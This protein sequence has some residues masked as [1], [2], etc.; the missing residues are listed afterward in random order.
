MTLKPFPIRL[1]KVSFT[2][3]LVVLILLLVGCQAPAPYPA[4]PTPNSPTVT[5]QALNTGGPAISPLLVG[6]NVWM[7]PDMRVWNIAGQAGL[8]I[9]R[10]G[11]IAYDQNMPPNTM[12]TEWVNNIKAMGAEPMIQVSRFNGPE[13]AAGV[14]KYFNLET[15]NRVKFWNIGNEPYCNKATS[16]TA[17]EVA[18]YIKPIASAMK[19]ADPTIQIFAPDEC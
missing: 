16:T 3:Y 7:Y 13:V 11:G 15:K 6:N 8:K 10:I 1:L 18:A 19:A 4:T 14:V 12:L 2:G 9:I 5:A 17:D